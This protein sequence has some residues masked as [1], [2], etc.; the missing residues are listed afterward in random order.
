MIFDFFPMHIDDALDSKALPAIDKTELNYRPRPLSDAQERRLVLII[1]LVAFP[2]VASLGIVLHCLCITIPLAPHMVAAG[3]VILFARVGLRRITGA[4]QKTDL[5]FAALY[6]AACLSCMVWELVWRFA[7][8]AGPIGLIAAWLTCGLIARQAAAWLLVAPTVD[9][10]TMKRWRV[11]LPQLIPHGLS[12]DCPELL[13]YT[14]SPILLLVTWKLS[15]YSVSFIDSGLWLWPITYSASALG[16]WLVWHL[17]AILILPLPNLGASLR[18]SWRAFTIFAT[19]DIHGCRAAGMFRFPTEWLRSPVRRW[20]LL[21]GALVVTGFSFGVYCPS[22]QYA[23]R[24]GESVVLQA[25]A[26]LTIICVFGPLVLGST[27][28]L[29]T[30]T[31]LARFEKELSTHRCKETTDWDN[32]VDRIINS[33]DKT[34]RE[35]LLLGASEVGD[36]PILLHREILDQHVHILGD[37]GASKTALA[38]GPQATQLIARADST[39]VIIDLKGDKALFES[40]RREA[41]RTRQLRFRWISNEVGKTTY[42]FNPFLQSHNVKLNVEQ[43]TQQIL[44]GLSLDYGIQYGAGYFTA[45]NEIVMNTIMQQI[46][47]R[48]F[49]ELNVRLSDRDWYKNIGFEEDWKQARHLGALVSRLASSQALNVTP[50]SFPND[51]CISRDAIDVANLYEEPQVVY[52][53]LRSAI[54]PTNAPTIARLFLW[55]MF[56]AASHHPQDLNRAYFFIDEIQ[57]V[58][59]DGIK[60]IFEQFRDIGGTL[61]AA[62]QTA[63]QLRRQGTDLGDTIDSCT[64]MKQIFR[65]SDLIS[66]E[67]QEKLSGLRR[68]TAAT[69]HQPYE[70]GSGDLAARYA[71]RHADEGMVRVTEKEQ[72]RYDRNSIQAI[73]ARRQSSLVR[74]TFGSG[75][76][77]FAGKSVAIKSDYHISFDQYKER[78][79][80]PWPSAPGAFLI[81][82]PTRS[83]PPEEE[84]VPVKT[85]AITGATHQSS[86]GKAPAIETSASDTEFGKEFEKRIQL[87]TRTGPSKPKRKR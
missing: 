47:I 70:R 65:A 83:L 10:E 41:A 57:Q 1:L 45:M 9:R 55:A 34:E 19:Y 46:G 61:I 35:H 78:R 43:M 86:T 33:E 67:R 17:L 20:S 77:Q 49:A 69:W 58:V 23:M 72:P 40:C 48:S 75:Y 6:A 8:Y 74:F 60:L 31:L 42:G 16:V 13:T 2:V 32:Y 36:Y 29:C 22:P 39:V 52:L 27:L 53:W 79:R 38:M 54:E 37:S 63:S 18:A 62:H 73:S 59:S 24:A 51:P 4:L 80:M 85:K 66:L 28:W 44:Q 30:G 81:A 76:T 21:I 15:I 71:E 68:V 64:A 3:A 82:P 12:F 25:L 84:S 26:N 7:E 87:R 56:T 50:E 14:V 5:H 11:N